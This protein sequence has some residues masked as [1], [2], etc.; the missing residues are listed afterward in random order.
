M[1]PT[2]VYSFDRE[3][4]TGEFASRQLAAAEGIRRARQH[5]DSISSIFVGQKIIPSPRAY[6]CARQVIDDMARRVRDDNGDLADDFLRGVTEQQ[7][8]DLD[9]ALEKAVVAWLE[10][11]DLVPRFYR[12]ESI[13]EHPVP[14][15]TFQIDNSSDDDEEVVAMG[16]PDYSA[17][18]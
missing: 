11:H 13:S 7:V 6:G 5:P 10:R 12:V 14:I 2:F 3:T 15:A 4:W 9:G 16:N 17:W 18:T 1:N 8:M